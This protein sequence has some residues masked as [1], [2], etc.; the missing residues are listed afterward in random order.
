MLQWQL[1]WIRQVQDLRRYKLGYK[2][3][4]NIGSSVGSCCRA[5]ASYL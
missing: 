5:N 2:P 1:Q 3:V 4:Y